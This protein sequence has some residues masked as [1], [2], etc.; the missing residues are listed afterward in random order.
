LKKESYPFQREE[1][2]EYTF[3]S[4]GPKGQITK[5]VQFQPLQRENLYNIGFGDL[6][7][8]GTVDDK[9]ES[10]NDDIVKVLATV[11][12]IIQNFLTEN[13]QARVFFMGSTVQRTRYTGLS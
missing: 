8:S 3:I 13:A 9:I 10:N 11:I 12:H 6:T 2:S 4:N 5:V 7:A 1:I